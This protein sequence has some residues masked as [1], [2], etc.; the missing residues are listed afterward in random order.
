[1]CE[2]LWARI[3]L[4]ELAPL[5]GIGALLVSWSGAAR[6]RT[7]EATAHVELLAVEQIDPF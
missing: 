1:M 3:F 5:M 2:S 7:L 6:Q 4:G